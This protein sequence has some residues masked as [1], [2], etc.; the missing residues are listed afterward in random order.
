M[1]LRCLTTRPTTRV[2][3]GRLYC[4]VPALDTER[5]AKLAVW[6]AV[7]HVTL[8]DYGIA[9]QCDD[10]N[11]EML[12]ALSEF[13]RHDARKPYWGLL[14]VGQVGTGKTTG[15]RALQYIMSVLQ[16]SNPTAEADDLRLYFRQ[17]KAIVAARSSGS[18]DYERMMGVPMLAIDDLGCESMDANSY[19]NTSQPIV[20]IIEHRYAERLVTVITSN[21]TA[22]G[23]AERYGS[24]VADRLRQ[25]CLKAP[26]KGKSRR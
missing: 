11:A 8:R 14:L 18:K 13:V 7:R 20:D 21:M 4:G 22:K 24:R 1:S 2:F 23:I 5:K 17:A 9:A 16:A 19:G 10:G 25:M 12:Q 15:A 3:D 6:A 26:C